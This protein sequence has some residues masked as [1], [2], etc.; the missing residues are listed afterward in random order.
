M[1]GSQTFISAR[2]VVALAVLYEL[3]PL[4]APK[5]KCN[6]AGGPSKWNRGTCIKVHLTQLQVDQSNIYSVSGSIYS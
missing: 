1:N 2:S 4:N 5:I 3:T 6:T